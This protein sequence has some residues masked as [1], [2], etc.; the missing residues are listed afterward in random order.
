MTD[1]TYDLQQAKDFLRVLDPGTSEFCFQLFKKLPGREVEKPPVLGTL[2]SLEKVFADNQKNRFNVT[3]VISE[4]N[5]AS[6][7]L[8]DMRRL[9]AFFID[10]DSKLVGQEVKYGKSLKKVVQPFDM[11]A[12]MNYEFP[13]H[14]VIE[15]SPG[16]Y[17]AYWAIQ[18]ENPAI[19]DESR[20]KK[21]KS[22]HDMQLMLAY[23]FGTDPSVCA[24]NQCMRVPGY[25][26]FKD[27]DEAEPAITR[28]LHREDEIIRYLPNAMYTHVRGEV[29]PKPE[30]KQKAKKKSEEYTDPEDGDEQD[31]FDPTDKAGSDEAR[32]EAKA[33]LARVC[34]ELA[35]LAE[36]G[37]DTFLNEVCWTAGG[38]IAGGALVEE[39]TKDRIREA[40]IECGIDANRIRDKLSRVI[41][42][43]M[44]RPINRDPSVITITKPNEV[45]FK[46]LRTQHIWKS[47]NAETFTVIYNG[48]Y[49]VYES[50]YYKKY[51]EINM[52][53]DIM[54]WLRR[55]K[56]RIKKEE[57][58]VTIP[59]SPTSSQ[60]EEVLKQVRM[61][62]TLPSG[63][64]T[65]EWIEKR[66]S[67]TPVSNMVF[68]TNGLYD[69]TKDVLLDCNPGFFNSTAVQCSYDPTVG[70]PLQW[71]EFLKSCFTVDGEYDQESVDLLR[72]WMGYLLT[73]DCSMHTM[74]LIVG[75]TRSG[76][77]T[78][79]GVIGNL[80]DN[81]GSFSF[82][83]FE[84]PHGTS[85]LLDK[86]VATAPDFRDEFAG[87][88]RVV[89]TL[90]SIIANDPL[91]INPK[92][93]AIVSRKLN[94]RL[95]IH[96]NEAPTFNDPSGA[97]M[98]RL[99]ILTMRN[100]FV[101]QEDRTLK[102]RLETETQQIAMW[103][104]QGLKNLHMVGSFTKPQSSHN[105]AHDIRNADTPVL[106]FQEDML[107][108][109]PKYKMGKT[110]LFEAYNL[111][112]EKNGFY[113]S[114]TVTKF[115]RDFNML[116][117]TCVTTKQASPTNNNGGTRPQYYIG[118][119]L[120]TDKFAMEYPKP[121]TANSDAHQHF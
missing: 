82:E 104:L 64:Y 100:S 22:F 5:G 44:Q 62:V 106:A 35:D 2:D 27:D 110:E 112:R 76:K 41:K 59:F 25:W 74:L 7:K 68:F 99:R 26:R 71:I 63:T 49:W 57:E 50:G 47:G 116:N 80:L 78:I 15:S 77:G 17:H 4:T 58:Y 19:D 90:L 12:L 43:G 67:N 75:P 91:P 72:E 118:V 93:Q 18:D 36:G 66:R 10:F 3:V 111:W 20:E 94:T 9:R 54:N 53:Q 61:I 24:F 14:L 96:A 37:R 89:S 52:R 117:G 51:T 69:V 39:E 115:N 113:K 13:P 86:T 42:Q 34:D 98:A 88:Q 29:V 56:R 38:Y 107:E 55:M 23:R 28:I 21:S 121:D 83:M 84:G 119:A 108:F 60:V 46:Y 45:A 48:D 31:D 30:T 33:W 109:N 105:V 11:D 73:C 79:N 65:N 95:M 114:V 85:A 102:D 32:A 40:A 81:L 103:A 120:K 6:R 101:G 16:N 8:A 97:M 92:G 70:E 1:N 87:R